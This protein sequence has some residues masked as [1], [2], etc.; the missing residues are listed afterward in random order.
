MKSQHYDS[1]CKY[2]KDTRRIVWSDITG[3]WI[4][5]EVPLWSLDCKCRIDYEPTKLCE[6]GGLQFPM[7]ESVAPEI[8]KPYWLVKNDRTWEGEWEGFLEEQNW[9][10]LGLIHINESAAEQ[11]RAALR[12]AN[13]QAVENAKC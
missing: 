5:E 2:Y 3:S 11:H 13:L 8:G 10:K 6:L 1:I 9:L 12:A 7:P 4:I